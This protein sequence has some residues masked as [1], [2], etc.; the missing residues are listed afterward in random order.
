MART[1][2]EQ[3]PGVE[4]PLHQEGHVEVDEEEGVD[5]QPHQ[6]KEENTTFTSPKRVRPSAKE[7][8]KHVRA[9]AFQVQNLE[10][11]AQNAKKLKEN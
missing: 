6:L 11:N 7:L 2:A 10:K 8:K 1:H 3:D 9:A 5:A 4:P